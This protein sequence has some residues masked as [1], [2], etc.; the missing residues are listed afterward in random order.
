MR[1]AFSLIE[2]TFV[3]V[4]LG[5]VASI[6][7]DIIAQVYQSYVLQRAQYR[8]TIKSELALTQIANRLRY[9]IGGTIVSRKTPTNKP[10]LITAMDPTMSDY[11]VIQWVSYDG[12]GFNA[13]TS[14]TDRRPGWSGFCDI[15]AYSKGSTTLPTPGSN[16]RL[17]EEIIRNL[18]GNLQDAKIYFA[19]SNV[20]LG[21]NGYSDEAF[22]LDEPIPTGSLIS[23]RYKLA[24]RS[25]AL[26]VD[27]NRDLWLYYNFAPNFEANITGP[28]ALLLHNVTTFRFLGTDG[29]I[30]IK[31]CKQERISDISQEYITACKEKV[32]F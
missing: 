14:D 5:I 31:L 20:S 17:S 11:K 10:V 27:S 16:P 2:L 18:G 28:R 8:A 23:E 21:V 19:D 26:V 9:A 22:E 13:G 24:W 32:I 30:R 3:I 4:V 7:S 25:L 15:S 12:E 29:S 6:G 1:R